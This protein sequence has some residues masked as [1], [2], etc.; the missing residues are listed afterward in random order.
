VVVFQFQLVAMFYGVDGV[1]KLDPLQ[2]I[3]QHIQLVSNS[4][5][6]MGV[7]FTETA[8]PGKNYMCMLSYISVLVD[9]LLS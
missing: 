8:S 7:V 3:K 2:Q 1:V 5:S 9:N 4:V 6:V